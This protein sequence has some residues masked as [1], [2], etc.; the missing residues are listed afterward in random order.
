M[1]KI[2]NILVSKNPNII[3]NGGVERCSLGF[4][5]PQF[6]KP[7]EWE[8]HPRLGCAAVV[9]VSDFCWLSSTQ[10]CASQHEISSAF[11]AGQWGYYGYTRINGIRIIQKYSNNHSKRVDV[12]YIIY[13]EHIHKWISMGARPN[14]YA[15][16]SL[17]KSEIVWGNHQNKACSSNEPKF[18]DWN[19]RSGGHSEVSLTKMLWRSQLRSKTRGRSESG[20]EAAL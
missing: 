19:L 5:V 9:A 14:H 4:G 10:T 1:V 16:S 8:Q 3:S 12:L 7:L 18:K 20:L 2:R 11:M 13:V 17:G 15:T 6:S